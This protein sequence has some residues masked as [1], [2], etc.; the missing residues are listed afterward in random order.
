MDRKHFLSILLLFVTTIAIFF[1]AIT[2]FPAYHIQPVP[3]DYWDTVDIHSLPDGRGTMVAFYHKMNEY[4]NIACGLNIWED[5]ENPPDVVSVVYGYASFQWTPEELAS[6][7]AAQLATLDTIG[8]YVDIPPEW[9]TAWRKL[10]T[11]LHQSTSG[12][13]PEIWEAD[14][15]EYILRVALE[16]RP[17]ADLWWITKL[18]FSKE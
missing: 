11:H 10:T 17:T 8:A 9:K 16:H 15:G 6:Y 3:E 7:R 4:Q 2:F 5:G 1:L 12:E 13:E 18:R 14:A